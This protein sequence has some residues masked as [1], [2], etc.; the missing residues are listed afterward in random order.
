MTQCI[1]LTCAFC[2]QPF[3]VRFPS[4]VKRR[5]RF[6]NRKCF[7]ANHASK[8]VAQRLK[9]WTKLNEETGCLEWQGGTTIWGYGCIT[10]NRK[11]HMAHRVSYEL[12]YGPIPI[13]LYVCHFCDNPPCILPEH[14]V[15][16]TQRANIHDMWR[17]KRGNPPRGERCA[18]A[19]L[20]WE[21]VNEMRRRYVTGGIT[22]A[23]LATEYGIKE[24]SVS[25]IINFQR[26]KVG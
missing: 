2:K 17:K 16:G 6:C 12:A 4:E 7:F 24:Q 15:L 25:K 9:K 23:Q 5:R 3:S 8:T 18:R 10:I 11:S 19:K 20:T 13:G 1:I 26:W 21:Q 22:Q 14:L